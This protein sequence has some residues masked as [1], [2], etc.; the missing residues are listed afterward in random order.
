MVILPALAVCF[1]ATKICD[2][3]TLWRQFTVA[4]AAFALGF[5]PV[6]PGLLT[7]FRTRETHVFEEAPNLFDLE[8][9][10]GFGR[11]APNYA[12]V[13]FA[14]VLVLAFATWARTKKPPKGRTILICASLALIPILILY[15]VSVGTSIHMFVP[16]HRLVAIPGIALCWALTISRIRSQNLRL[17]LCAAFVAISA[18]QYFS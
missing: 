12:V 13:C 3:K 1:F 6:I 11:L 18:S 9:T 14:A 4:L 5:L 10:F 7:L 17:L 15:G 8:W 2:R 16:R